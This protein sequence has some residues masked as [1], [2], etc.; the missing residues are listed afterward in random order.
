MSVT[1]KKAGQ[2]IVSHRKAKIQFNKHT[3][4]FQQTHTGHFSDLTKQRFIPFIQHSYTVV[5]H[6]I[7]WI[8]LDNMTTM[9][10][11]IQHSSWD[12][13]NKGRGN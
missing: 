9:I 3:D 4:Q 12:H 11:I 2:K 7:Q 13:R 5:I 1:I 8:V 6:F 10:K